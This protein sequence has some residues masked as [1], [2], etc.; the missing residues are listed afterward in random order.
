MG[1]A[2]PT[3]EGNVTVPVCAR[4]AP[5][6]VVLSVM[7]S[8]AHVDPFQTFPLIVEAVVFALD[9]VYLNPLTGRVVPRSQMREAVM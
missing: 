2:V 3:V 7:V 5:V 8:V 6:S 4:E 9:T 1:F